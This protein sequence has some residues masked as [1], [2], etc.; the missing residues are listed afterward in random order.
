MDN[1]EQF[2]KNNRTEF[3][4]AVPNTAVWAKIE[5]Q[6]PSTTP[7][8]RRLSI[9]HFLSIA[10]AVV[11]LVGFGVGIGLHLAPQ[12]SDTISISDISAE[13]AEVENYYTRQVSNKLAMLSNYQATTP[14]IKA[15]LEELDTWMKSLEQELLLV[16]KNKEE[17]VINDIINIYKTKVAILE[18]VLESI[19]STN[20]TNNNQ[21]ERVDI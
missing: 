8:I 9:R 6:L 7:Q 12:S 11:L 1:L 17:V 4:A 20:Q 16:P 18:K 2:I 21:N 5:Q 15:D 19:Q 3:E 10:A 13:Y 14:E